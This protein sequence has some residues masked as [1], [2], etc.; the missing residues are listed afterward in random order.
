MIMH[1]DDDDDTLLYKCC[2]VSS[3]LFRLGVCPLFQYFYYYYSVIVFFTIVHFVR[4]YLIL[5]S[6][7]VGDQPT[8]QVLFLTF[9]NH[10]PTPQHNSL[11]TSS[12]VFHQTQMEK[13]V[14]LL[15]LICISMIS[16][17]AFIKSLQRI[18]NKFVGLQC[19]EKGHNLDH[20]I[21]LRRT[22]MSQ[23][24]YRIKTLN[25]KSYRYRENRLERIVNFWPFSY[26][27]T[28]VG[29]F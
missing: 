12:P 5:M 17:S 8:L 28:F 9:T 3:S 2:D 14:F 24:T 6:S 23:N 16:Q 19:G 13:T 27:A 15:L 29:I 18:I 21:M 1:Y 22:Q 26:A 10:Q 20:K 25:T 7:F 11:S 4:S